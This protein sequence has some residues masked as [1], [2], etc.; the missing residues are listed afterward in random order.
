MDSQVL[1]TALLSLTVAVVG[2]VFVGRFFTPRL[3]SRKVA[4]VAESEEAAVFAQHLHL[5]AVDF[6]LA[7]TYEAMARRDI[8]PEENADKNTGVRLGQL[9]FLRASPG[10]TGARCTPSP[11]PVLTFRTPMKRSV[12]PCAHTFGPMNR[13]PGGAAWIVAGGVH[14]RGV[15][16]YRPS[17]TAL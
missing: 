16:G 13:S 5:L 6:R 17:K 15:S 4:A 8:S 9:V 1:V 12:S 3:E 2:A 10:I 7:D 14:L 11:F